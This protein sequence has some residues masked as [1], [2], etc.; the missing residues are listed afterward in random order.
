MSE[1]NEV[2]TT[3][4]DN[5][6][7]EQIR[8]VFMIVKTLVINSNS[9]ILVSNS[10]LNGLLDYDTNTINNISLFLIKKTQ[11]FCCKHIEK[12]T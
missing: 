2:R 7:F 1:E 9:K 4:A 11:Y 8:E 10:R 5:F 3:I 6:T 12:K